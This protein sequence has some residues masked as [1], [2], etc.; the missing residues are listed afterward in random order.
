MVVPPAA[1]SSLQK[2]ASLR[3][4]GFPQRS[5]RRLEDAPAAE[6]AAAVRL[7]ESHPCSSEESG[8][9]AG[10]G[11]KHAAGRGTAKGTLE[12]A[13]TSMDG[14]DL[15]RLCV[16]ASSNLVLY[17]PKNMDIDQV[18][19]LCQVHGTPAEVEANY[20]NNKHKT[21]TVYFGKLAAAY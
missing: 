12:G 20:L 19:E 4:G 3:G 11:G 18:K 16:R 6:G 13:G 10:G 15:I 5:A 7:E 9:G 21:T 8:C 14:F 2:Q 1:A 17:L